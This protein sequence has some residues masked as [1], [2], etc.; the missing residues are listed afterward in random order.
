MRATLRTY[1]R[2]L[3]AG[4]R[5]GSA[6]PLAALGGLVANATFGLLKVGILFATVEAGGGTVGGYDAGTMSAYIWLSQ[7]LLGSVNLFGRTAVADR[8]KNGDIAVDFVRPLDVQAA[9]VTTEVGTRL[10][11]LLPRGVP[12]VLL[13]VLLVG[14]SMPTTPLPYA[15]GALSVLLGVVLSCTTVY[16]VA[17]SR[18]WLVEGRGVEMLYMVLSGFLAGLFVPIPLFPGW[19]RAV[20]GATPFPSMLQVPVDVLSGRVDLPTSA[21]LVGVQLAWLALTVVLGAV[22]TRAGRARLEVQGG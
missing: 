4:F 5:R 8:I 11:A 22:L 16:L 13:G 14:M 3:A 1:F 18:F 6:Y 17:V 21:G 19:L 12:S 7:G 20:A 10:F 9:S 2:L 15:L